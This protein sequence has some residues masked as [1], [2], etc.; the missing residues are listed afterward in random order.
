VAVHGRRAAWLIVFRKI[1]TEG[2][3]DS[4]SRPALKPINEAKDDIGAYLVAFRA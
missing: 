1:D 3:A 2:G 4:W